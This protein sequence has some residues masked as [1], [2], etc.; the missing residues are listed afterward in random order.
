[1]DNNMA[2]QPTFDDEIDL[3]EL[4]MVLWEGKLA[5]ILGTALSALISV[6]AAL[7]L[8][9]KYTSEAMLAPRAEGGAGGTLG[10]L[11]SQ[12]GGLAS[13]AG[14]NVGGLSDG[15]KAAIAIEML[16][17][18]EFFGEYLYDRV[19][20]DLMAAQGW[21]PASKKSIVDASIYDSASQTWVRDV[22]PGFQVKP[23]VQEAHKA[24]VENFLSVSE[25]KQ[26]GFVTLAVTH[27]SPSV[28]RD[29]VFLIVSGANDAVRARD[30]EEAENSIAFLNEQ[31]EKTSLV[32]LTEVFAELIEQQTK[33][34]MLAAASEEYVF[35][36]IDPPVAPEL[37]SEPSR[38]LICILG[39]LLG[40]MLSVV[41]VLI[42][43]YA[44]GD[45]RRSSSDGL[46]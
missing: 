33:T 45:G 25:D 23:S 24:F 39:V 44:K 32:S 16:K 10:Q 11:A 20:I 31:R 43:H 8:P 6:S 40:G 34:V 22:G 17:S 4:F 27:F 28:A 37:K 3:R 2:E 7:S 15:G 5:I 19:L 18:R 14:I 26:T 1:M 36:I 42:R 35:Q 21:D 9:N 13:L 12:Y 29:W 30:V 46:R 38:A 41:Y